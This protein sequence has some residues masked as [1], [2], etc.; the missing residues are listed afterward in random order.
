MRT[1]APAPGPPERALFAVWRPGVC[2]I[3]LSGR[4]IFFKGERCKWSLT[5]SAINLGNKYALY[6][7]LSTFG[8]T[9][10][11]TS[12]ALTAQLGFHF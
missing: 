1:A 5:L 6:N 3:W 12:R 7:F 4:T 2:L 8:G 9:H 11:V 10:Y